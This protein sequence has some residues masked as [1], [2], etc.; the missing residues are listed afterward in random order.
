[1][2]FAIWFQ[3]NEVISP[4]TH[5][6]FTHHARKDCRMEIRKEALSAL[7]KLTEQ[8]FK[9]LDVFQEES[10]YE[11]KLLHLPV[12]RKTLKSLR[13]L[14]LV[15]S[16]NLLRYV[17][18]YTHP[19]AKIIYNTNLPLYLFRT[20]SQSVIFKKMKLFLIGSDIGFPL[21]VLNNWF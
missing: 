20:V 2:S 8:A 5:W 7:G 4:C 21:T 11:P 14:F 18:G 1:M 10:L 12:H 6:P 16:S 17:P 13:L 9:Q 15:T 3:G 19:F